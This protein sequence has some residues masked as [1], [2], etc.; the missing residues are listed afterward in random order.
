M[1]EHELRVL[2]IPWV[3]K[4]RPKRL[5]D[6]VDQEHVV[7]RL[8]AYVNRGDMPNLLFAGPPGTGKTTAALCL[9]RELFGDHWRDNFLELNASVSANTPILVRRSGEILRVTF[10]DLDRW[11]FGNRGGE[12]VDTHDLEVLTVDNNFSVT[13][14][15]V[16]KLIR[17]RAR[18]ILRVHLEDGT[19]ELTGNHAVMI[20][21]E[22]GLRAV[23]ASEI[24]EGSFLL[25]FVT[26][27]DERPTDGGT[28]V[29][30]AEFEHRAPDTSYD[31]P[32]EVRV[33]LLRELADDGVIEASEE[34]SVDLAW[35]ARISGIESR[36]T[37]DGVE[38]VRGTHT[39]DLLPA[40]PVL[41][42]A[43]RIETD[44]VDDL[45]LRIFD[46][47]VS[48]EIVLDI[49][50]SVDMTDLRGDARKAYRMLR[51][52]ARSDVHAIKVEEL[53]VVDYDGYVYDVSVP[54]NEMFFAGEVPVLLHNSDERG[55]DVIRTKV[56]NF[57]RT[58][59]MGGARFK[60]I[61]LDEADNLTRDSQQALRRIMEM[62]SDAC[63]FILAANYSSAIIDPIQSRCVVFKFTKLPESAI[64]ERLREIAESEGVEITEDALDAIVYVSEG[65]MRRAINV[66]QAAAALGR[67]IDE[68]TVFQIAATARPEE[69]REMIYH[70]WTGDFERARELLHELLTR[71]G[72][73]GEDV[74]R[75]VHREIFDMDEIPDEAIPE[76]VS[77]VGDF[78]YRLIR[79]SDERIQLEALLARIHALGNEYS[80][81]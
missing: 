36:V 79:G 8:K 51:T 53:D 48:K 14:A 45:E 42:L 69:V 11:Y 17:H 52:L 41:K 46:G 76:L 30:S 44:L 13:W 3:E 58:R 24:E 39:G 50:S 49:L 19:I 1:A 5:D 71:Y 20:L 10:E 29:A 31:L 21:D 64:K 74:V 62:Y 61:F 70:A 23:K 28:V 7:E 2:E 16:S 73:S 35:L 65:D 57:A 66:L 26:E 67:K 47:R 12:Y 68:D 27:L 25:G 40:D 72:M 80:G 15:P 32:L 55:I 78:E 81:G 38:L 75:Q 63:R 6:I 4:Y 22:N 33:E 18:K 77:T 9:A 43:E 60:I 34:V 37:D 59:P 56:K 54:G